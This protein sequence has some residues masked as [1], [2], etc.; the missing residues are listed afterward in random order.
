MKSSIDLIL[1]KI[2]A[3]QQ[4]QDDQYYCKGMFPSQRYNPFW[5]YKRADEN[6]YFSAIISFTLQEIKYYLSISDQL[7]VDNICKNI[8]TN[9]DRYRSPSTP[10]AY[11]FY[12]THP[13]KHYPNGYFFSRFNHFALAD[14]ADSSVMINLAK[15]IDRTAAVT[16]HD[17][18]ASFANGNR[19]WSQKLPDPYQ[20]LSVYGIWLGTGVMPIEVDFCVVCNILL[21]VFHHLLEL[22]KEDLDSLKYILVSLETKDFHQKP[23]K[24]GPIY[25]SPFVM[26][27]HAARLY[28]I[29]PE[30]W[31]KKMFDPISK[32]IESVENKHQSLIDQILLETSKH[33]IGQSAKAIQWDLLQLEKE[34]RR[35]S[36]FIAPMLSGTN[37][38]LFNKLMPFKLFQIF[39]SC[40]AYYLCLVLE[41]LLL[42]N[43]NS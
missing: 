21:F 41:H 17:T 43:K 18:I 24:V 38:P 32:A 25:P 31:K 12:Q 15:G 33:K 11:N 7:I 3:L 14:D 8:H 2:H 35:F 16:L 19:K 6:S 1:K 5:K 22:K 29:L 27:Y 42:S 36:F 40:E 28:E 39:S 4:H 10:H 37:Y 30:E 20:K 26:L 23:F 9:F 34:S 13:K